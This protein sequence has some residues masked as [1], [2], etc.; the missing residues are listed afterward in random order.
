MHYASQPAHPTQVGSQP[1]GGPCR[2]SMAEGGRTRGGGL[3]GGGY[4]PE[5][6]MGG[7][8][9]VVLFYQ[10]PILLFIIPEGGV[11]GGGTYRQASI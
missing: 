10:G 9:R 5:H 7:E 4:Y 1:G 11:W 2:H 6:W 8:E 3:R